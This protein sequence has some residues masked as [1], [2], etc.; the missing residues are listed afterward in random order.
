MG[1]CACCCS[2]PYAA[3]RSEKLENFGTQTRHFLQHDDCSENIGEY[4]VCG[5]QYKAVYA[6]LNYQHDIDA[7]VITVSRSEFFPILF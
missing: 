6:D 1:E 2:L 4:L 7:I 3:S 5:E